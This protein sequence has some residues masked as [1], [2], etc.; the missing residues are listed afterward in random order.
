MDSYLSPVTCHH[1]PPLD[2]N[3]TSY[4]SDYTEQMF[5]SGTGR[6]DFELLTRRGAKDGNF[7]QCL[8]SSSGLQQNFKPRDKFD[9]GKFRPHI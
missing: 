1:Q 9:L 6:N 7:V 5:C 8:T 2:S 3:K 4:I